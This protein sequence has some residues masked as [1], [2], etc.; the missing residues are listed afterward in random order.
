MHISVTLPRS[1]CIRYRRVPRTYTRVRLAVYETPRDAR[2]SGALN[3]RV[4]AE[5]Y[6]AELRKRPEPAVGRDRN[7]E[8]A[9]PRGAINQGNELVKIVCPGGYVNFN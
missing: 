4:I 9:P 8:S 6:E 1:I 5:F 3:I 2:R 7:L